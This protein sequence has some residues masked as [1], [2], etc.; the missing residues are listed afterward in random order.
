MGISSMTWDRGS[1][2]QYRMT[3]QTKLVESNTKIE[4]LDSVMCLLPRDPV[5]SSA[6]T[7]V[8]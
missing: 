8:L 5:F 1:V 6:V 7:Q 2:G 4:V 3:A